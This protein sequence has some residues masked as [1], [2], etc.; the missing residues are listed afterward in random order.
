MLQDSFGRIHDYLRISLTD[1]CNFRCTYCMPQEEMEWMPQSKLMS[2]EEIIQLAETFIRLGVKK[3]RLTG[4]EPLVRKE[5]DWILEKLSAHPVELTLTTNGILIHKHI[6]ALKNAGVRSVNVSLD[7]LNREKFK[8]LTRRDQYDQVWENILL[9]LQ[10]GFRVKVNSVALHGL[11][12]DEICDFVQLTE[13]LPL[14]VRFIEFM[15]F[16]GNHWESKKVITAAQMLDL[17]KEKFEVVKLEDKKHDTAKKYKVEGFEGTF[18]F[19]TTMSEHFCGSCNRMRL[20]ADGKIKNCLFGKEELDLLGAL[21]KGEDLESIIRLSVSR[22]HAVLGG[23]FDPDY[24][25]A[26]PEQIQ[27]R[28]MIKIGG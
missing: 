12:E 27:N 13:K 26:I 21:R 17:V 18:A 8:K 19:I 5:F 25:K 20:T 14:H 7:T 16:Q 22:K 9:L 3:I 10:E 23:Q 4:G 15:P 2:Q 1:H 6:Q 24:L 28:S 11:I